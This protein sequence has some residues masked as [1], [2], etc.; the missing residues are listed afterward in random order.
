MH[1]MYFILSSNTNIVCFFHNFYWYTSIE[2]IWLFLFQIIQML[3][4]FTIQQQFNI[5]N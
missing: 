2:T 5:Y 3:L 1:S 4:F